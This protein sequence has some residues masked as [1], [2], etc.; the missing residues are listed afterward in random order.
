MSK[1]VT[2]YW[3]SQPVD[4][5]QLRLLKMQ[6]LGTPVAVAVIKK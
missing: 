5:L 4:R 6:Q 3:Q 1:L 2:G